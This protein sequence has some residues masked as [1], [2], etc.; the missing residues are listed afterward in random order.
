[1][2][3]AEV[4]EAITKL[5]LAT[6]TPPAR[7]IA[8]PLDL[9]VFVETQ[10]SALRHTGPTYIGTTV[11][12]AGVPVELSHGIPFGA[13]YV[14]GRHNERADYKHGVFCLGTESGRLPRISKAFPERSAVV[15]GGRS[16]SFTDGRLTA[17]SE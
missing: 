1:M 11:T 14:E 13:W 5:T 4:M 10:L 9:R 15:C 6:G 3:E 12:V 7:I 16:Y 17:I 2:T 8:H